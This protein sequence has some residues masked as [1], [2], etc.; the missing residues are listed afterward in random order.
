MA[1]LTH[2]SQGLLEAR[3]SLPY[4]QSVLPLHT[5]KPLHRWVSLPN[6]QVSQLRSPLLSLEAFLD[7][8]PSHLEEAFGGLP[9]LP[10][11]GPVPSAC[12]S[13]ITTAITPVG[14]SLSPL[15]AVCHY[16]G[17]TSPSLGIGTEN[18][19]EMFK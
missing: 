11:P 5:A 15:R 14:A 8:P 16:C 13:P 12:V 4:P 17:P 2:T 9:W 19:N 18:I 1:D 10:Y 7:C 3:I 6:P